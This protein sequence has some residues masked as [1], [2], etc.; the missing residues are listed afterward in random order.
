MPGNENEVIKFLFNNKEN[1]DLSHIGK[2]D[3]IE[4]PKK[5]KLI[6]I[7]YVEE[8]EKNSFSEKSILFSL[9]LSSDRI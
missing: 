8:I 1:L 3:K 4:I 9:P 5:D 7:N 6:E 2:I